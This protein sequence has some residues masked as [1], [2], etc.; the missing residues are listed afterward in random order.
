MDAKT[1]FRIIRTLQIYGNW[2]NYECFFGGNKFKSISDV[3]EQQ[4]Y[5][6]TFAVNLYFTQIE[7]YF[8]GNTSQPSYP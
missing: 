4:T 5:V 8:D 2:K 7:E 3:Q 1:G 6:L